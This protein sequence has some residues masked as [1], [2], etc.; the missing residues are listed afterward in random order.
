MRQVWC[1][2]DG[3]SG[4]GGNADNTRTEEKKISP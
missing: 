1:E 2:G 4:D 3:V